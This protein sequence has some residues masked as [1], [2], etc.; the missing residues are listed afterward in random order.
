MSMNK[1]MNNPK[2]VRGMYQG[3]YDVPVDEDEIIYSEDSK[4][5][6]D[7][8][9][10]RSYFKKDEPIQDSYKNIPELKKVYDTLDKKDQLIIDKSIDSRQLNILRSLISPAN[11]RIFFKLPKKRQDELNAMNVDDRVFELNRL[12]YNEEYEKGLHGNVQK[13]GLE[14]MQQIKASEEM[15]KFQENKSKAKEAPEEIFEK[16]VEEIFQEEK[17]T[18]GEKKNLTSQQQFEKLIDV[19]YKSNPYVRSKNM[20]PELEVRFGTRDIKPLT[21]NDYDNVIKKLKSLGFKSIDENGYYSLRMQS[22]YID[23]ITGTFKSSNIRTEIDGLNNIQDYCR[24]NDLKELIKNN[25]VKF[26]KKNLVVDDK[27]E[28]IRPV[29]FDE[30]NFRVSYVNEENIP[31]TSG[32]VYYMINN[33]SN[34]KKSYRFINRV[35]FTHSDYPINIDISIV[36]KSDVINGRPKTYYTTGESDVFN[37]KQS[38]EIELEIDN[39]KIGPGTQFNNSKKVIDSLRKVIKYILSGLQ[40]TNYPISYTEQKEI[41]KSYMELVYGPENKETRVGPNNFIGPNS[42]TLQTKN[43]A[44]IDENSNV[45]NIRKDFVVTDKADGERH[46]LYINNAG[47]IY[48]ISTNMNVIFTGAKTFNKDYFDTLVDGEL[49]YHDKLGKFINL[50]A[51]FDLYYL[52]KKDVRALPFMPLPENDKIYESRYY[53]MTLFMAHLKPVSVMEMKDNTKED[54]SD[55]KSMLSKLKNIQQLISPIRIEMKKFYP[56]NPDKGNIFGACKD[57]LTKM[58][59]YNTDGLILNHAYYGVGSNAINIAGPNTKIT[60]EYSFKWKPPQYNTVDFLVTTVKSQSGDDIVKTIFEEGINSKLSTQLSEYKIIQLR[61]TFNEK[62]HGFINPCQDIIDDKLPEYKL[63]EDREDK[64]SK[65][66]Q[67]YPTNPYDPEAGICNIM[68]KKDDNGINQMFTEENEVFTDNTII[69]FRYEL[70]NEKGWRWVPLRVRYDKTSRMLQGAKDFG[71]AYHV[72]N[73]NWQSIHNPITEDMICTGLNVPP[74]FVDEDIYYNKPSGKLKTEA[75]KNF[76]N[77]YVKK[78]LIKSVSNKGDI[79]IDYACG[80]GGDL[81]KWISSHL[82]F[83]FGIDLSKDN[84]ENKL[85]GACARY[86]KAR[87]ENKNM[88]YALFVN[89]NSGYNIKNGTAMLNDKAIQITKAV[90][91]IGTKDPEKIGKGV[92]RQYGIGQEGFN[93]SSC[94]FALHYFLESPDTLQGFMRNLAECTKLNGYFIGAAY[95][96]KLVFNL[97]K[98]KQPGESIEILEDNKKIWQIVKLYDSDTF[99]D[100][101]SSIGYKIDVYQESINQLLP[102]YLV[103][104]DYLNRV[105]ENYG[106]KLIDR[107]EAQNLGLPEGSGLF[108]ELFLNMLDEISKN[109]YKANDYGDAPN[110]TASEKKISFLNRY[111]VFKK[112]RNVD[113]QKVELDLSDYDVDNVNLNAKE[114]KKAVEVAKKEINRL[115]PKIRQLNKKL[116]LVPATEAVDEEEPKPE[117]TKEKIK[118]KKVEKPKI[119]LIIEDEDE[120]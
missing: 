45:I 47:K 99:E 79:L 67:F 87:R 83:V 118:R 104:F 42:I 25:F 116:L 69:E 119:K 18:V 11:L 98:K 46:L 13:T 97:L 117:V 75:L 92:A 110:M 102:E 24:N 101:S 108:S 56:S 17:E 52:K 90:F 77:L 59:E 16:D 38:F 54:I 107:E 7:S 29:N 12:R 62:R 68:L 51:A 91:G 22:E 21:K 32:L 89:G 4:K 8:E 78:N 44:P 81:P 33:W 35:T 50:Y 10:L 74:V 113:T 14:T 23:K 34:S 3:D 39:Y 6:E 115:K 84:L 40:N 100:N 15:V 72:A 53:L 94:Q 26:T 73:S 57:V 93:I 120:T 31:S 2:L 60:W 96:G 112:F 36:K 85:D 20:N 66:V 111:F 114:T 55:M 88:L 49:I 61:C 28:R 65:P 70:N 9:D 71:N 58:Y 63:Y 64:E 76:H 86:L 82:S 30:F 48:L 5:S 43:I 105:M 27:K 1:N 37:K 95:D 109:K 103:N 19:Y 106:F 41:L 80:K